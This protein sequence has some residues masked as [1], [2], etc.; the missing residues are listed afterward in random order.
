MSKKTENSA[1]S[2]SSSVIKQKDNVHTIESEK[3]LKKTRGRPKKTEK[4]TVLTLEN[5]SVSV[6]ETPTVVTVEQ[7]KDKNIIPTS[8]TTTDISSKKKDKPKEEDKK[9]K[10]ITKKEKQIVKKKPKKV[11]IAPKNVLKSQHINKKN[12]TVASIMKNAKIENQKNKKKNSGNEGDDVYITKGEFEK[13]IENIVNILSTHQEQLNLMEL[14]MYKFNSYRQTLRRS[15]E[16]EEEEEEDVNRNHKKKIATEKEKTVKNKKKR[17]QPTSLL[18]LDD[19][20]ERNIDKKR[21]KTVRSE[22]KCKQCRFTKNIEEF[23]TYSCQKKNQDGISHKYTGIRFK[24]KDC[25]ALASTQRRSSKRMND[26]GEEGEDDENSSNDGIIS[27][28][29]D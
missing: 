19:T 13:T 17:K 27:D 12:A 2:A 28:N 9:K 24:C 11:Q 1:S 15:V 26:D 18:I 23:P 8:T 25:Y 6:K 22:R 14:P 7:V 3:D 10:T 20:S 16:D 4:D 5:Q 29:D 21:R